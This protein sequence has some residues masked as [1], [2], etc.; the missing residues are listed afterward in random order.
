MVLLSGNLTQRPNW[1]EMEQSPRFV[2]WS[3]TLVS[4]VLDKLRRRYIGRILK[5][6]WVMS[7]L[8]HIY[9][10]M[11]IW[12]PMGLA[13][14]FGKEYGVH[15]KYIKN[16]LHISSTPDW[17]ECPVPLP[18]GC[19]F[20]QFIAHTNRIWPLGLCPSKFKPLGQQTG[21]GKK[22]NWLSHPKCK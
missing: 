9:C 10:A 20:E 21:G 1:H 17:P 11:C 7:P 15:F 8:F 12:C 5:R 3:Q 2:T 6:A 4:L 14:C 22:T 16:I 13:S 19:F 18:P